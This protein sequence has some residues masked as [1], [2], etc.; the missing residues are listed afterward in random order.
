LVGEGSRVTAFLVRCLVSWAA[1]MSESTYSIEMLTSARFQQPRDVFQVLLIR[2]Q[3]QK[4]NGREENLTKFEN[5]QFHFI[6]VVTSFQ[7]TVSAGYF[8]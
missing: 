6:N 4:C 1:K 8:L 3:A 7:A 5:L 2:F